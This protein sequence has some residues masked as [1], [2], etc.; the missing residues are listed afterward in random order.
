MYNVKETIVEKIRRKLKLQLKD[1]YFPFFTTW[2]FEAYLSK[3][4]LPSNAQQSSTEYLNVHN[5]ASVSVCSS[6]PGYTDP[7]CFV[8]DGDPQKLV[9]LFIEYLSKV[10]DVSYNEL[11]KR[12]QVRVEIDNICDV[13]EGGFSKYSI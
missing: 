6:I 12:N 3:N 8:S 7:V 2:D 10:S 1:P 9:N 13:L 4:D 5:V 11:K